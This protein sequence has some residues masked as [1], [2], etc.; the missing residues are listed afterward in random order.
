MQLD[1]RYGLPP[2]LQRRLSPLKMSSR[3]RMPSSTLRRLKA[4]LERLYATFNDV[5]SAVDPVHV[6]RRYTTPADREVVAF[7]ASA[8]AFGR[9]ASVLNT[10]ESL[11]ALLGDSP[12][13]FVRDFE[14]ARDGDCLRPLVHRWIRGVDLIALLWILRRMISEAGSIERFFLVGHAPSSSDVGPALNRFAARARAIDLDEVYGD[15]DGRRGVTYFFPRPAS[16]SACKR[17][18]LFLRWMVRRDA[19]DLGVW[20]DLSP[21]KLVI[22]LDTHVIRVSRCLG[23]T[24]YRSPGWGMASEITESLRRLD[25]NDPVRFD[26]SICHLGMMD[27]CGFNRVQRDHRCPLRGLCR[28]G[29]RRRRVSPGPLVRS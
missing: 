19:I 20:S 9:V 25:P 7:C 6:V 28:P 11:L 8:L 16:G 18:N 17:L 29:G 10:T 22:P 1:F 13:A 23:L 15:R 24:R 4:P 27:A 12:A 26:F 21:S 14:P 2:I 3:R 5:E